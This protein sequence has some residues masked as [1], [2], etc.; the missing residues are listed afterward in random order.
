MITEN[1]DLTNSSLELTDEEVFRP[2]IMIDLAMRS[3]QRAAEYY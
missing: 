3:R 2:I 1:Y